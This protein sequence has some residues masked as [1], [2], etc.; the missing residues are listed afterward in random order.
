M[1]GMSLVYMVGIDDRD[2]FKSSQ[3][4]SDTASYVG[5]SQPPGLMSCHVEIVI[6]CSMK[7]K[8]QFV[9]IHYPQ[10]IG[11]IRISHST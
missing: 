3:V 10:N 1:K 6:S 11:L 4:S 2:F 5:K 7:I 8:A 9:V